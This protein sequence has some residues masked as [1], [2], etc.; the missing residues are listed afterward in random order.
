MHLPDRAA[1]GNREHK[2]RGGRS[3]VGSTA[4]PCCQADGACEHS[5]KLTPA[6]ISSCTE[7]VAGPSSCPGQRGVMLAHR[8]PPEPQHLPQPG[9][10]TGTAE[11]GLGQAV[12]GRGTW[13]RPPPSPAARN[14]SSCASPP[15]PACETHQARCFAGAKCSG[16]NRTKLL[17]PPSP[18]PA[19][20]PGSRAGR[21]P[22]YDV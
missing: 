8:P 16:Q 20:L 15:Q 12:R 1:T 11:L 3:P 14:P 18:Q 9:L 4:P 21:P 10:G 6:F 22:G 5:N 19:A 13:R 17:L 2:V 7:G